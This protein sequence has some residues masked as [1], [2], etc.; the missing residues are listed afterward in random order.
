MALDLEALLLGISRLPIWSAPLRPP[1]VA[2]PNYPD[3][4]LNE[5]LEKDDEVVYWYN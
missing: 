2:G 3:K 1:L 5:P 4:H